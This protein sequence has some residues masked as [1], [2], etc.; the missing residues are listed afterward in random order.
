MSIPRLVG[1]AAANRVI[2]V[3]GEILPVVLPPIQKFWSTVAGYL[4]RTVAPVD[5]RVS[6]LT[7]TTNVK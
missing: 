2:S 4:G 6:A 7:D 1:D 5:G 3:G